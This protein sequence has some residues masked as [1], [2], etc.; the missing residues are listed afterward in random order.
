MISVAVIVALVTCLSGL[1]F[2]ND[3]S[4][5]DHS[6]AGGDKLIGVGDMGHNS[7]APWH[8]IWDTEFIITNPNCES[9]LEIRWVS[10]IRSDE[11]VIFA[12]PPSELDLP[13]VLSGHQT[14][15]LS[16]AEIVAEVCDS[17]Q[18]DVMVNSEA[19]KYTVEIIWTKAYYSSYSRYYSRSYDRSDIHPLTGW[20]KEKVWYEAGDNVGMAISEAEMKL[21]T[22]GGRFSEPEACRWCPP[23]PPAEPEP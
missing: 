11:S 13:D 21:F 1:V 8:H 7:L 22:G 19:D 3:G 20:Q 10:L 9:E 4:P 15:Q 6:D 12:G 14:I 17:S 16:I 23:T 18:V 5:C 2:A